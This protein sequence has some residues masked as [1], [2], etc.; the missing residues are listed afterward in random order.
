M[1]RRPT[2]AAVPPEPTVPLFD[3]DSDNDANQPPQG[4]QGPAVLISPMK[5]RA[6]KRGIVNKTDKEVWGLPDSEIIGEW[7]FFDENEAHSCIFRG[8]QGF[9]ALQC[10]RSLRH[11]P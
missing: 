7:L 4:P 11:H 1:P 2:A 8:F 10:I 3:G 9:M 6:A 5:A